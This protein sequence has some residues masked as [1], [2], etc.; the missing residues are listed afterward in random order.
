MSV[1]INQGLP[2][3]PITTSNLPTAILPVMSPYYVNAFVNSPIKPIVQVGPVAPI[4]SILS[5]TSPLSPSMLVPSSLV[6]TSS[7]KNVNTTSKYVSSINLTYSKPSVAIYEN[8]NADPRIHKRMVKYIR[9]KALD[10]WLADDISEVLGYLKING[11]KVSVIKK[12]SEFNESDRNI[13]Y[14][15][16]FIE[17]NILTHEMVYKIASRF[18]LETNTNWYDIPKY[19]YHLKRIVKKALRK[20]FE[21]LIKN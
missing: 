16:N 12:M 7:P 15:I 18:V 19:D 21:K 9:F 3:I 8:L 4:S 17:R 20:K 1:F 13:E 11:G 10:N 5:A 6:V 2:S 14:K